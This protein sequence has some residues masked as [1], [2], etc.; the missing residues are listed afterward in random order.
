MGAGQQLLQGP[1]RPRSLATNG[2]LASPLDASNAQDQQRA[3]VECIELKLGAP[4]LLDLDVGL[5][6]GTWEAVVT[7]SAIVSA[8]SAIPLIAWILQR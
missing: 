6:T 3:R 8:I 4:R 2:F 1:S 7:F 5:L